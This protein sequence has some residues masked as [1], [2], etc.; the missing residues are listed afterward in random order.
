MVRV[1]GILLAAGAGTRMGKP[2]ALVVGDDGT[3]WLHAA[4]RSLQDGGCDRVTVVL[5]AAAKEAGLLLAHTP[6]G[7]SRLVVAEDWAEGMGASLRAGLADA[8]Q[9]ADAVVVTLVDL[10]DVTAEVVGRVVAAATGPA[11]LARAAYDATPGHPVLL[12]RD[13]WDGVRETATGDKGAR[14]YLAARDVTLVECGDLATGRDVDTPPWVIEE[15]GP[16]DAEELAR[17]H[18][19]VWQQAYDG[20]MPADHLAGLDVE[21]FTERWRRRLAGEL[22]GTTWVARDADGFVA[23]ASS[24]PG[25]DEDRPVELELYAINLLERTHGTGL[26]DALMER[27]V[28][29]EPAYLWV[30]GGNDRAMGFY[31]RHGFVDEG[32]RKPEP[33]TG[34]VEVRMVR[35]PTA[36]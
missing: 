9:A 13:H 6:S 30:L 22:P 7:R 33:D 32:G 26:A 2:K 8:D 21:A 19:L 1:D 14:D 18:V 28:G 35:Q 34:N 24:G 16:D 25:R 15:P 11:S 3:P 29:D 4:L 20:L 27:A 17:L 23:F 12:G 31:R 10:P 36:N 5:G